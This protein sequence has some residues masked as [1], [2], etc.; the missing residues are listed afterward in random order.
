MGFID[1]IKSVALHWC[2]GRMDIIRL[3]CLETYN[4]SNNT[5][6]AIKE[7]MHKIVNSVTVVHLSVLLETDGKRSLFKIE[8][9]PRPTFHSI[10]LENN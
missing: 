1:I 2:R 5:S 10:K 3:L 4:T 7:V 9:L 6:L 8:N